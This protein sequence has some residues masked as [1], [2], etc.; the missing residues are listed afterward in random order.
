MIEY[1]KNHELANLPNEVWKDVLGYEGIYQASNLGRVK[2]LERDIAHPRH[3]TYRRKERILKPKVSHCGYI[4]GTIQVDKNRNCILWHELV[5]LAFVGSSNL[6]ID[7]LNGIKTDN[8]LENLEYVNQR[9]NISRYWDKNKN[10]PTGVFK[11]KERF[12]SYVTVGLKKHYLGMYDTPQEAI[13]IRQTALANIDNI[14]LYTKTAKRS[15]YGNGIK[16]KGNRFEASCHING[17]RKH[18]GC[19]SSSEEAVLARQKFKES[20]Q[21]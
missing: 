1:Y 5:M 8:R 19:Y 16:K 3:G 15:Q 17:K 14:H 4:V 10:L 21:S 7:H 13:A 11:E 12:G 9:E 18:V 20:L 2:S 6:S